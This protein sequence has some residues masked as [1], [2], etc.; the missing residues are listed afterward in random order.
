MHLMLDAAR[1]DRLQREPIADLCKRAVAFQACIEDLEFTAARAPAP[2]RGRA[3]Q[4]IPAFSGDSPDFAGKRFRIDR[5]ERVEN[6]PIMNG[7][8]ADHIQVYV[9]WSRLSMTA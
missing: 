4:W 9:L 8:S 6:A 5:L 7:P 3:A 2:V 1:P